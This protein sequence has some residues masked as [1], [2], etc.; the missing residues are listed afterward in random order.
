VGGV[1]Y[2]S[3]LVL[4]GV[5]YGASHTPLAGLS[6]PRHFSEAQAQPGS[7]LREKTPVNTGQVSTGNR[8]VRAPTISSYY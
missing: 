8:R 3:I 2:I 5:G 1:G 6:P 7:N 4:G